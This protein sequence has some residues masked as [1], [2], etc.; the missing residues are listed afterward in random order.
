MSIPIAESWFIPIDIFMI[1]CLILTI[2]FIII[3]LFIMIMNKT[4]HTVPMM[5]VAN[6]FIAILIFGSA[7]LGAAIFTLLNDLKQIE[8]QD[9]LCIARTVI[10]Y[11]S[12]GAMIYSFLLQ[13]I[14]RYVIVIYPTRLYWQTR[15][16]QIILICFIWILSCTFPIPVLVRQDI[17]YNVDNQVCQTPMRLSFSAIYLSVC[18]YT[19]PL[20]AM[21]YNYLKLV[22]HV[23]RI[24]RNVLTAAN[25]L[26]RAQREL[27]MIRRTLILVIIL[28]TLGVPYVILMVMSFFTDPPKYHFR[29]AFL[30]IDMSLLAVVIA[31]FLFTDPLKTSTMKRIKKRQ[32]IVTTI[33]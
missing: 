11:S 7:M 19:I 15:K 14:Y 8:D 13:S 27:K 23:K 17:T 30:F 22:L 9:P 26:I 6:S 16:T 33:V 10:G 18:I 32:N 24:S 31:L 4:C 25:T 1:I 12:C 21:M 29:I 20:S 5:L 2:I 28:I 3:F